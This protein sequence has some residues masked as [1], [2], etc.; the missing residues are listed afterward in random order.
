MPRSEDSKR[1]LA[2]ASCSWKRPIAVK[3]GALWEELTAGLALCAAAQIEHV[4]DSARFG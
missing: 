4:A 3:T 1:A 2:T